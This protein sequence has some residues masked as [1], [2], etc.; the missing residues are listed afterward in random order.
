MTK[1]FLYLS[2]VLG[3]IHDK[4]QADAYCPECGYEYYT[5]V[6]NGV[7]C[8]SCGTVYQLYESN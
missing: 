5:L 4:A 6:K 7:K 8:L 3:R 2:T 1:V